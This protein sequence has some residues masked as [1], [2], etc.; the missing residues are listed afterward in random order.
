VLRNML[1][2]SLAEMSRLRSDGV[3]DRMRKRDTG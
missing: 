3:I 2:H 1:G